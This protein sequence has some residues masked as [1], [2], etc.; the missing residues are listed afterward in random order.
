MATTSIGAPGVTF[1]DATVQATAAAPN[2]VMNV[3][4]TPGT[5]TKPSTV[6][7]IKVTVVGGGAGGAATGTNPSG[8][9]GGAAIKVYPAPSIPGP[10][11]YT[12]GATTSSPV[13]GP[14]GGGFAGNA[15]AFGAAPVTVL[16]GS[17]G[18]TSTT[19]A[20]GAASGGDLN[21]PGGPSI[22]VIM[23]SP[24]GPVLIASYGGKSILGL[25]S[26]PTGAYGAGGDKSV[27]GRAGVVII[28]EF[29]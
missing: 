24:P 29:Y 22:E 20:G 19:G 26:G 2:V 12:V 8:G 16:T 15:S 23:P 10:Q 18:T 9:G 28:E 3:Y 4:T 11:P 21:A 1:P 13:P 25:K 7:A 27:A 14:T 17:G 5:W 6:K